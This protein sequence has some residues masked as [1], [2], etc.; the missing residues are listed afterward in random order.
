[1]NAIKGRLLALGAALVVVGA[2]KSL[3]TAGVEDALN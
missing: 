2:A 1:M 3:E